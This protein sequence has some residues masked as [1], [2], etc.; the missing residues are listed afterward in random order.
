[1]DL[2]PSD[3]PEGPGCPKGTGDSVAHSLVKP[4]PVLNE[5]EA[6]ANPPSGVVPT[7]PPVQHGAEASGRTPHDA[8]PA[9]SSSGDRG[10]RNKKQTPHTKGDRK[11]TE[12]KQL[13][14]EKAK[15]EHK[16]MNDEVRLMFWPT[17]EIEKAILDQAGVPSVDYKRLTDSITWRDGVSKF[18]KN[19]APTSR[20]VTDMRQLAIKI[21]GKSKRK[22]NRKPGSDE[23][24]KD[25]LTTGEG[26]KNCNFKIDYDKRRRESSSSS[27]SSTGGGTRSAP[28]FKIPKFAPATKASTT[29]TTVAANKG[30]GM[31]VDN[32][33]N[34]AA[35]NEV[36]EGENEYGP[37]DSFTPDMEGVLPDY[38]ST[39]SNKKRRMDYPHLLYV[40][41]GQELREKIPKQAWAIFKERLNE[42]L[43]EATLEGEETPDIDWTGWKAGTG[44]V[45]TVDE[46]SKDLAIAIIE[47]IEV[48]EMKFKGYPKGARD[49]IKTVTVKVPTEFKKVEESKLCR[50]LMMKNKLST[51]WELYSCKRLEQSQ[52]RIL[53]VKVDDETIEAIKRMGGKLQIGA[54]PLEVH[55][56]GVKLS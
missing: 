32:V 34:V 53:R 23:H 3:P 50:A 13:Q 15:A 49:V 24:P 17:R 25:R 37:L 5:A 8:S 40:H 47:K 19:P 46:K 45:A 4:L 16:K 55:L 27:S 41:R 56:A 18:K 54:R 14:K 31:E 42:M 51:L 6:G 38:A 1:M 2:D 22:A 26:L 9:S 39:T 48:A 35:D 43:V 10:E 28:A 21:L 11:D 36:V 29:S 30:T 7:P 52:E 20:M 12:A 33:D 44:V